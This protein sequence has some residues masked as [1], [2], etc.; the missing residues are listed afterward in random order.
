TPPRAARCRDKRR[1]R[2]SAARPP[3]PISC[4]CVWRRRTPIDSTLPRS[5]AEYIRLRQT[6][7]G[8]RGESSAV[9][10]SGK[11]Y[12]AVLPA[13]QQIAQQAGAILRLRAFELLEQIAP[14]D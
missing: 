5:Q 9:C 10:E 3:G 12:P 1:C 8:A 11:V 2:L 13:R 4:L 6:I 7:R 14:F